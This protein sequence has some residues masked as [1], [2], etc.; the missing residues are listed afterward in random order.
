MNRNLVRYVLAPV[1][2]FLF[3]LVLR[4]ALFNGFVLGDDLQELHASVYMMANPPDLHD[5][6][7]IRFGVWL[8][9]T[10]FFKL[11]GVSEFS[12]FLPTL[13][14][15]ASLA[16]IGYFLLLRWG[17][18]ER[19]SFLAGLFIASAPFEVLIGVVRANDLIFS[20]FLALGFLSFVM[21]E[22]KPILQ[23]VMVAAFLWL[24]FYVKLWAIYLLPPMLLYYLYGFV[25]KREW[26]GPLSFALVTL[27]LHGAMGLYFQ[28][29]IGMFFPFFAEHSAT[30]P[31]D[32]SS[33]VWLFSIYPQMVF[34][35]SQ[36]G[37][38]LFGYV[39]HLLLIMLSAKLLL[40]FVKPKS[41][42][43][44]FDRQDLYLIAFYMSFFLL[45]EFF[46]NTFVF[47]QYY[48]A[49]RIFRYLAP[50]SFPMTLHLAKLVLDMSK[51]KLFPPSMKMD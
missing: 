4:G 31:V 34:S 38:T 5:A 43:A 40:M 42:F 15:S 9:N 44:G 36:F 14:M 27:L 24:A 41:K 1:I 30:Y 10:A 8:Y 32:S 51:T 50:I 28:R 6:F 17:Y 11:L 3:S 7:H 23:G 37:T 18:G 20:W 16:V 47:D 12:F 45:L 29:N 48:S 33:L 13:M 26:T 22:K 39:P 19:D 49:P 21:L 35:G 46:P 25:K 2:I